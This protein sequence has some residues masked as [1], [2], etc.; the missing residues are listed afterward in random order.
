MG[1][2]K[3]N[4]KSNYGKNN[5]TITLKDLKH[6][7]IAE[8]DKFLLNYHGVVDRKK[9]EDSILYR[10]GLLRI[11]VDLINEASRKPG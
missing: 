2:R 5:K 11:D 8:S 1:K 7:N 9:T 3:N 6:G 10:T 4:K